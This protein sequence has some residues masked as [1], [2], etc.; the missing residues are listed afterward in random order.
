MTLSPLR[1]L[2]LDLGLPGAD[3]FAVIRAKL[4]ADPQQPAPIATEQ[5]VGYRLRAPD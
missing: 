2:V 1:V 5:G 4:E 3:G